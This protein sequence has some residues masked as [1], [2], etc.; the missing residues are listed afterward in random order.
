MVNEIETTPLIP[1]RT[2]SPC[3]R[4]V[5]SG[6]VPTD[7][8]QSKAAAIP[9][10]E[11]VRRN[12]LL[13][14]FAATLAFACLAG[15]SL[16]ALQNH[17]H[18]HD[19][20]ESRNYV[21][22]FP[23]MGSSHD[24]YMSSIQREATRAFQ[25]NLYGPTLQAEMLLQEESSSSTAKERTD[26]L[27]GDSVKRFEEESKNGE[28]NL[29]PPPEGCQATVVLLRHCEK[30]II[31]EHCNAIGFER[32]KYIATLF[33]DEPE[34][35]WPA[36][37][38]LFATAPGDRSNSKVH[39]WREVETLQPLSN[40]TGVE[41]DDQYGIHNEGKFAKHIFHLLRSGEMCG[42]VAVVS[43]KHEDMSRLARKLGCGPED[44]CPSDWAS[45][46]DFDSTWQIL[47]SY[48]K[49]LYPSFA[50]EDKKNK[51]KVW[52]QHPEWWITGYV[53][54]ENFDPL[55]FGKLNGVY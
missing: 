36:P 23:L 40:K 44:G 49:Q 26:P 20:N 3:T 46:E 10:V 31:R 53:Q 1:D 47:Y 11:N 17:R 4:S 13:L 39:N 27:M 19:D 15:R 8:V 51:H 35:R 37:S 2:G 28:K 25:E 55:E 52:G 34:A 50:I 14:A 7:M 33:G 30:G 29:P 48:H 6:N 38:Y 43:W 16:T 24:S 18:G 21:Q 41:I 5:P 42:K 12:P 32:A 22:R 9:I 54:M 45:S